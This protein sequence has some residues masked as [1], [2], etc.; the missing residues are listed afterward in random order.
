VDKKAE[1]DQLNLE[2]D[3]VTTDDDSL[4]RTS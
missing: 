2:V 3:D 4:R 1:C